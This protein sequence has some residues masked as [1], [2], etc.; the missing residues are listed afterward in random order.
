MK[1]KTDLDLSVMYL[2]KHTLFAGLSEDDIDYISSLAKKETLRKKEKLSLSGSNHNRVYFLIKG[3]VKISVKTDK[4]SEFAK[5]ILY[6]NEIFGNISLTD[7][8]KYETAQALMPG[9]LIY[10]FNVKDFKHL[11]KKNHQL[12][13][14]FAD[15]LSKKLDYLKDKHSIWANKGAKQ[16]LA[17]FLKNWA[18]KEGEIKENNI[19]LRNYLPLSD[20]ADIL[21][22]SRQ[23]MYMILDELEKKEL[24][25]YQKDQ[26]ILSRDFINN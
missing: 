4:E 26:I 14:N 15:N 9:T 10:H 17:F 7:L 25:Y 12:A 8:N 13:L 2:R 1:Y 6:P 19:I 3:K 11:L 20:I 22:I 24:M 21:S 18:E 16:R 5:E 23:L